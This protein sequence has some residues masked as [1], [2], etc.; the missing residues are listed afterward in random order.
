[1]AES[2]LPK[3]KAEEDGPSWAILHFPFKPLMPVQ[4]IYESRRELETN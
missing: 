1:M 3:G 2:K 4:S